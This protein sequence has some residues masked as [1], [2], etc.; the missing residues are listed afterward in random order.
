M[1]WT[2]TSFRRFWI[3]YEGR[4]SMSTSSRIGALKQ[5]IDRSAVD[6]P[7]AHTARC[8]LAASRASTT[9]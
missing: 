9:S 8:R 1:T 3:V 7:F 4:I 2:V 5:S 6:L